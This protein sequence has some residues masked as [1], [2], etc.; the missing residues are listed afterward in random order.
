M[1]PL[2][3][4]TTR[5]LLITACVVTLAACASDSATSGGDGESASTGFE[6]VNVIPGDP[7]WRPVDPP[8]RSLCIGAQPGA[9]AFERSR[10]IAAAAERLA[11]AEAASD[12]EVGRDTIESD[13]STREAD[14]VRVFEEEVT[15]E[16]PC[17]PTFLDAAECIGS[18]A[19]EFLAYDFQPQS[20]GYGGTYGLDVFKGRVTF[21]ALF[22]S[23]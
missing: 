21:V 7:G 3:T 13:T 6:V 8:D 2:R 4:A 19:P 20:C 16:E 23:W 14:D 9:E 17:T 22:A 10:R 12:A 15:Q 1:A 18:A 5:S 11:A